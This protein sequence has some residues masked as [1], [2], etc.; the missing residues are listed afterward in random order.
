MKKIFTALI[1][2]AATASFVSLPTPAW[3]QISK[4]KKIVKK[5]NS[6]S[7]GRTSRLRGHSSFGKAIILKKKLNRFDDKYY[8]DQ[9]YKYGND[10][11]KYDRYD[12]FRGHSSFGDRRSFGGRSRFGGGRLGG[13]TGFD[14]SRRQ[15]FDRGSDR[16]DDR[17]PSRR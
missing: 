10:Y 2:G 12:G 1:L 17:R 6:F 15:D 4:K 8:R 3:S 16:R 7:K 5:S 14:G 13:F 9:Y 11:Y